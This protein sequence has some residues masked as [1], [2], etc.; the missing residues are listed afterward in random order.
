MSRGWFDPIRLAFLPVAA[1]AVAMVLGLLLSGCKE[2]APPAQPS[3]TAPPG[4][5]AKAPAEKP[6]TEA[7]KPP[8]TPAA[9][10]GR[11]LFDGKTLTG[12]KVSPFGG[13]GKIDIKDG[14]LILNQ[15]AGDLTGVTWTAGGLPNMN[16]EV[17]L[18]AMRVDGGDFFCG[19]TFP[20]RNTCCS[21]IVGGWGGSLVGLSCFDF[22]DA[23]N[24]ETTKFKNFDNNRWYHIRVR[25]TEQKIEAWIDDEQI[26]DAEPGERKISVRMEVEP[27]QPFGVAAWRTRAALRSIQVRRLP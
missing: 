27:S 15:G 18:E 2:P 20:V 26:V 22:M 7:P 12:W 14:Q 10:D 9:E 21:L 1:I 13:E 5:A 16:Y 6:G 11:A 25:V 19:L 24:N 8:E 4:E 3:V 23:A 17:S